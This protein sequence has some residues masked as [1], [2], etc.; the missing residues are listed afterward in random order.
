MMQ[1]Y[2]LIPG[3]NDQ[4]TDTS[5]NTVNTIEQPSK[6]TVQNILNFARCCQSIN[7][8][9]VKIKLYLN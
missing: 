6:R 4:S 3:W 7:V 1:D 2:D 9:D 8:G 5:S